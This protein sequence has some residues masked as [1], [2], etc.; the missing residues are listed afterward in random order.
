M[1]FNFTRFRAQLPRLLLL[2]TLVFCTDK[3]WANGV[4]VNGDNIPVMGEV[5]MVDL[6]T[7]TSLPCR[8]MAPVLVELKKAYADKATIVHIDINKEALKAKKFHV[9]VIPTQIFF[10]RN[11]KEVYRH[12]GPMDRATIVKQLDKMLTGKG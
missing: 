7:E 12:P 11:N 2:S 8:A 6:G 4:T 10:D 3:A 1:L 5:T 9:L